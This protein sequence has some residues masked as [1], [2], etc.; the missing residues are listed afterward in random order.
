MRVFLQLATDLILDDD[1]LIIIYLYIQASKELSIFVLCPT[2]VVCVLASIEMS[3][4]Q[5]LFAAET[6]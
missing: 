2:S 3:C 5:H 1:Y 4:G 6:V